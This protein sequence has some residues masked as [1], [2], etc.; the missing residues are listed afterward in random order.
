MRSMTRK[1]VRS[2]Q[3]NPSGDASS[4]TMYRSSTRSRTSLLYHR[5][6]SRLSKRPTQRW[7]VGLA[8]L[9]AATPVHEQ[10][11]GAGPA[12]RLHQFPE[13]PPPHGSPDGPPAAYR[14]SDAPP[15][16]ETVRTPRA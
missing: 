6:V 5:L 15:D 11:A 13:P 7:L 2:T 1:K 8:L 10:L 16:G 12:D 9:G 14:G 3:P 4:R